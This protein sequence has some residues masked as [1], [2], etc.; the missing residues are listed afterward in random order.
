MYYLLAPKRT[1]LRYFLYF[2]L[3]IN[4]SE[5]FIID[6]LFQNGTAMV[7]LLTLSLE[8]QKAAIISMK[9]CTRQFKIFQ[10]PTLRGKTQSDLRQG[11]QSIL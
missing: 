7:I 2:F 6:L 4:N 3:K 5:F 8:S 10:R 11:Y 1:F 9:K